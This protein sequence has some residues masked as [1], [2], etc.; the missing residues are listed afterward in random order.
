MNM[1][2]RETGNMLTVNKIKNSTI[3]NNTYHNL[4]VF[5]EEG[6]VLESRDLHVSDMGG[7]AGHGWL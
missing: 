5:A 2:A 1:A 7:Q 4:H 6:Q 3:Y